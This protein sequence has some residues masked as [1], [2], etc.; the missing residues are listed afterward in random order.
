MSFLSRMSRGLIR[1]AVKSGLANTV[2][3]RGKKVIRHE[4]DTVKLF[5]RYSLLRTR[6]K[7]IFARLGRLSYSYIKQNE[8]ITITRDCQK[9]IKN[10]DDLLHEMELVRN[11]IRRRKEAKQKGNNETGTSTTL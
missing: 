7:K 3:D 2:I 4:A 6:L 1:T 5:A 11:E 10:A 8:N 9:I